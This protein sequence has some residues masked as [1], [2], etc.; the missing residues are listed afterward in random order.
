MVLANAFRWPVPDD[1]DGQALI[2]LHLDRARHDH[3]GYL[4]QVV[5]M[6][7]I[8]EDEAVFEADGERLVLGRSGDRWV[9]RA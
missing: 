2:D 9:V 3:V 4:V 1:I 5:D 7:R 8:E 6:P